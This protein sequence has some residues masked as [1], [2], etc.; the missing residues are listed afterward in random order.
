MRSLPPSLFAIPFGLAGLSLCWRLL[1]RAADGPGGVDDALAAAAIALWVALLA[2]F[3]ARGPRPLA[4]AARDPVIGPFLALAPATGLLASRLVGGA[5]QTAADIVFWISFAAA[6]AFGLWLAA[7]WIRTPPPSDSWHGGYL[8]PVVAGP[9][10]TGAG[11]PSAG[12]TALGWI[13]LVTGVAAWLLVGVVLRGWMLH[14]PPPPPLVP[15]LAIELAPPAVA[16]NAYWILSGGGVDAPWLALVAAMLVVLLIQARRIPLFLDAPFSA[17]A[18]AHLFPLTAA[19]GV[20]LRWLAAERPPGTEALAAVLV[21]AVSA[22]AAFLVVRSA[23]AVRDGTF[24]PP[25]RPS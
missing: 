10:L 13:A 11:A 4:A 21:V 1:E 9:L 25:A 23:A 5:L 14:P 18:W 17:S 20:A 7:R 2:A 19:A 24:V 16:A 3:A 8:V 12:S 6:L 15:T 22:L